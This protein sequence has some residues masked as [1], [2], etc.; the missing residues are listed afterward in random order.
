M[1]LIRFWCQ[2]VSALSL[3]WW[4]GALA[5]SLDMSALLWW[6][7]LSMGMAMGS[8]HDDEPMQADESLIVRGDA[9]RG[10]FTPRW[11]ELQQTYGIERPWGLRSEIFHS[12]VASFL[13]NPPYAAMG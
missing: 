11:E 8:L 9:P 6:C 1:Y 5:L 10:L 2:G 12:P 4:Q 13:W 7:A 3:D